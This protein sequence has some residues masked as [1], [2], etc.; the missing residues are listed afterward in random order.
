MGNR[1]LYKLADSSGKKATG[2]S[3]AGTVVEPRY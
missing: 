2:E 1:A 3:R